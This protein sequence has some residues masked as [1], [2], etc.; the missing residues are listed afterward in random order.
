MSE[1]IL[2]KYKKG[3]HILG[4]LSSNDTNTLSDME[5]FKVFIEKIIVEN[6]LEQLGSVHHK[7]DVGGFTSVIC[8]SESHIAL[9]TWPEFNMATFDVFLCNYSRNNDQKTKLIF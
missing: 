9:H 1:I 5:S 4:E 7:F 2:N 8:L 6:S 3:L